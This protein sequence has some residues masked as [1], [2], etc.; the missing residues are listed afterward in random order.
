MI[1]VLNFRGK[2]SLRDFPFLSESFQAKL[3]DSIISK[4]TL[5][6]DAIAHS[7][8]VYQISDD[9]FEAKLIR[10]ITNVIDKYGASAIESLEKLQAPEEI[11]SFKLRDAT[12]PE[13]YKDFLLEFYGSEFS[14]YVFKENFPDAKIMLTTN[15]Y[16]EARKFAEEYLKENNYNKRV[17]ISQIYD[18]GVYVV[19]IRQR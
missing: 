6:E 11:R 2:L 14:I 12:H 18:A 5:V 17:Y 19:W 16:G 1:V 7:Q 3:I 4:G 9:T 8:K 10:F 15:S 13:K